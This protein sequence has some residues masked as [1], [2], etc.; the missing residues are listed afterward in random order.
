[1]KN[2][3]WLSMLVIF[4]MSC[5]P[6]TKMVNKKDIDPTWIVGKW[7]RVDKD[8]FEKWVKLNETEYLGVAYSN[9]SGNVEI[10]ENLRIFKREKSWIYEVKHK[11]NEFKPVEFIW[12]PSPAA[13]LRFVNANNDFPQVVSYIQNPNGN[14][15][16]KIS[17]LDDVKKEYFEFNKVFVQ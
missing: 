1:M 11:Q 9:T 13:N 2:V 15:T 16:A 6:T 4:G 10:E 7:K 14:L 5:S 8:N 17:S 12:T 3:I